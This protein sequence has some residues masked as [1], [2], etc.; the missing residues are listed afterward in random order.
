M[1]GPISGGSGS[2]VLY[3]SQ[4]LTQAQSGVALANLSPAGGNKGNLSFA[5]DNVADYGVRWYKTDGTTVLGQI[6]AEDVNDKVHF[7]FRQRLSFT[8][9]DGSISGT[10]IQLGAANGSA[11]DDVVKLP[12]QGTASGGATLK[13][14]QNLLLSGETWTAGARAYGSIKLR[15]VP[16]DTS[17]NYALQVA[18]SALSSETTNAAVI[19]T[20][21]GSASICSYG[22]IG[23][24]NV[25]MWSPGAGMLRLQ[26]EGDESTTMV[27]TAS[28]NLIEVTGDTR[29]RCAY[30]DEA[31]SNA[32]QLY[33]AGV[34]ASV[35]GSGEWYLSSGAARIFDILT[36]G[37]R[38][39]SGKTF[40][41]GNAAAAAIA[42][43]STHKLRILDSTGTAYDVLA[44][45]A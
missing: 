12:P 38:V 43:A 4:T 25:G 42:V 28:G 29:F 3:T 10:N 14:S 34:G 31:A 5:G 6:W 26:A 37:V 17:Q 1:P 13:S 15:A 44:I 11:G 32:L 18:K 7:D 30:R 8:C 27:F 19:Q 36:A 39:V 45:A 35:V 2:A 41:L 9:V 33:Y 24:D 21:S 20:E 16:L 22:F 23:R 40:T